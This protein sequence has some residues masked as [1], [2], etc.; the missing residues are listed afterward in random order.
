MSNIILHFYHFCRI[1]FYMTVLEG[2]GKLFE[3]FSQKD[4]FNFDED[5][6][7]LL[8]KAKKEERAAI[9]CALEEF[10]K[11][12]VLKSTDINTERYWILNKKFDTFEQDLKISP[13]T[14]LLISQ[15]INSFCEILEIEDEECDPRNI[16]E[17]DINNL[18]LICYRFMDDK[19][20]DPSKN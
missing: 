4:K 8:P 7:K 16:T 15:L 17:Q 18:L 19:E 5:M 14:G 10:E 12:E 3:W 6:G 13:K 2:S 1:L 11:M 9:K 20:T